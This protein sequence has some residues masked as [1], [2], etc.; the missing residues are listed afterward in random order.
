MRAARLIKNAGLASLAFVLAASVSAQTTNAP[1]ESVA[2]NATTETSAPVVGPQP[3]ATLIVGEKTFENVRLTGF[4][5][6]TVA[7]SHAFGVKDIPLDALSSNQVEAL[8]K[9]SEKI[10]IVPPAANPSTNAPPSTASAP[11]TNAIPDAA[12]SAAPTNAPPSASTNAAPAEVDDPDAQAKAAAATD[13][14]IQEFKSLGRSGADPDDGEKSEIKVP[15]FV[16]VLTWVGFFMILIGEAWLIG[17]AIHDTDS[18]TWALL[19]FFFSP[20]AGIVYWVLHRHT[21]MRPFVTYASGFALVILS[22]VLA[23]IL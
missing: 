6:K 15:G 16:R 22:M 1:S 5:G 3:L 4:D 9:T 20:I 7:I 2:T 8:N 12:T 17:T 11:S 14:M 21:A 19:I 10:Q 18:M 13:A 23:A